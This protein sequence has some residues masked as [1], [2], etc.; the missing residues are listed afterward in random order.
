[1]IDDT[2]LDIEHEKIS[3]YSNFLSQFHH[4]IFFMD[5]NGKP[6]L[7][8]TGF[9]LEINHRRFF[10]TAAHVANDVKKR[11][12]FV[13]TILSKSTPCAFSQSKG[14]SYDN[15][16]IAVMEVTDKEPF[17]TMKGISQ[18]MLS[19]DQEERRG[20]FIFIGYPSKSQKRQYDKKDSYKIGA[21]AYYASLCSESD[22]DSLGFTS[23][24]HIVIKFDPKK[25]KDET[26]SQ[27]TF[28]APQGMSGG[29]I[30]RYTP[31][32]GRPVLCGVAHTNL[33]K[34]KFFLGTS[35]YLVL[36]WINQA[37]GV[38]PK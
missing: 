24:L 3:E 29:G 12:L 18:N 7:T 16:D 25:C 32:L 2:L 22:Y 34:K 27:F 15:L 37:Y 5:D 21:R 36:A 9:I 4:P 38:M 23:R 20:V 11:G 26:G 31:G 35:I 10:V 8:G 13:G 30:W 1:M 6:K 14:D 17:N 28:P 19:P 33:S